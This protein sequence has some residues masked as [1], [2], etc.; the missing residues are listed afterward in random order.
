MFSRNEKYG[1]ALHLQYGSSSNG[2]D[3]ASLNSHFNASM[4]WQRILSFRHG[5]SNQNTVEVELLN[6]ASRQAAKCDYTITTAIA[7][8]NEIEQTGVRNVFVK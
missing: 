3:N 4:L 2:A 6:G 8:E 1:Q 5:N 7:N